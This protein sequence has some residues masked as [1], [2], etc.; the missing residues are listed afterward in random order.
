[1]LLVEVV[2]GD[3]TGDASLRNVVSTIMRLLHVADGDA[4][5]VVITWFWWRSH[6]DGNGDR[7]EPSVSDGNWDSLNGS[8]VRGCGAD[9]GCGGDGVDTAGG[10]SGGKMGRV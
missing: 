10:S 5:E 2:G 3:K 7:G 4:V 1:M 8:V 6:L 9:G